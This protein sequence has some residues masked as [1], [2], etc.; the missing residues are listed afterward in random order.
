MR[1]FKKYKSW[2][3]IIGGSFFPLRIL[4]FKKTKWKK[5]KKSLLRTKNNSSFLDHSIAVIRTKT[6][7]RIKS[8]YKN[9][10]LFALNLKQRYD[11][12]PQNQGLFSY[13]K[14][15]YL[16]NYLKNEYR[17]D[18][19]V[20]TLN[21]FS[22]IYEARQHIKNGFILINNRINRSDRLVLSK[23][24]VLVIL[25]NKKKLPHRI[26]K[27]FKFSFVEVDYYTQ[28]IVVLKNLKDIN[29]QDIIYN[30]TE[31]NQI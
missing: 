4:K 11:Y 25:Q 8:Y 26:K 1:I 27:E 22:S 7:D 30:F 13:E 18:F 12:K 5:T 14:D 31:K 16:K 20:Y 9:K 6:W 10:L 28:T 19:L 29:Y 3:K 17:V 21:F 2:S 23:G 24:D 15:F